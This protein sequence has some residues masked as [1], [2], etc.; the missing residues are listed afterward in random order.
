MKRPSRSALF[1][2]VVLSV[3]L[4]HIFIGLAA[5]PL[6]KFYGDMTRVGR[7]PERYFGW[8]AAQPKLDATY[9][10]AVPLAEADTVVIG[11]SFSMPLV[12]QSVLTQQGRRIR[13]YTWDEIGGAIC[14]DVASKLREAGFKGQQIMIESVERMIHGRMEAS[15]N[16]A[17]TKVTRLPTAGFSRT[18]PSHLPPE[19]AMSNFK[20][21]LSAGS[22]TVWHT[23]RYQ[24]QGEALRIYPADTRPL[25]IRKVADGCKVFS[26]R[27]C[28]ETLF[29]D[30]SGTHSPDAQTTD[31]LRKVRQYF[32]GFEVLWLVIPDKGTVYLPTQSNFWQALAS[33]PDLQGIDLLSA[34]QQRKTAVMDL[35]YPN[36]S[37][38]SLAGYLELGKIVAASSAL[39]QRP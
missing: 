10:K 33:A 31:L 38:L 8:Q 15:V 20:A 16:C 7:L 4:I 13:T 24:M 1:L 5:L 35:Y 3:V 19:Q 2:I 12:W 11:D 29:F 18:A 26:H 14:G 22:V 36:D 21:Q 23:L 25:M 32:T 9:L 17:K 34:F 30:T 37:H 6:T 39:Q 27:A 28:P